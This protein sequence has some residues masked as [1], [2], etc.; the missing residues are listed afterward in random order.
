[1]LLGRNEELAGLRESLADGRPVVV[2]GPVGIGKTALVQAVCGR[3]AARVGQC[4][5]TFSHRQFHPV[6]H[7]LGRPPATLTASAVAGLVRTELGDAVL[8]VEDAHWAD[9]ASL[10][11]VVDLMR[12]RPVLLTTRTGPEAV[13][14]RR[15]VHAAGGDVVE[16]GPLPDEVL[17]DLVS[18]E[19]PSLV[20]FERRRVVAAAGGNP[21]VAIVT[22]RRRV[23]AGPGPD[24]GPAGHDA[25]AVLEAVVATLAPGDRRTLALIGRSPSPIDPQELEG[26]EAL[27]ATGLVRISAGRPEATTSLLSEVAWATL[28]EGDRHEVLRRL[29]DDP[30]LDAVARA[31]LLLQAGEVD[32]ALEL[33]SEAAG[34]PLHRAGQ[35]AALHTAALAAVA[36]AAGD[37]VPREPAEV[38][39]LLVDAAAALN[40]AARYDAAADVLTADALAAVVPS[41]DEAV[42]LVRAAMGGG[43][44]TFRSSVVQRLEPHVNELVRRSSRFATLWSVLTERP[45][46]GVAVAPLDEHLFA[47]STSAADRSHAAFLQMRIAMAEDPGNAV[48]WM[49]VVQRE[50]Q[51]VADPTSDLEAARN[52]VLVHLALGNNDEVR[53]LAAKC[54]ERADEAGL[55]AWSTEF[56]THEVISRFHEGLEHDDDLDWLSWVRTAPV[57]LE[58]RA[59][60]MS[61]LVTLLADRGAA[62]RSAEVLAPWLAPSAL[63]GFDPMGQAIVIWTAAQ[64]AWAVGDLA[65]TT[66]LARWITG[67][68][69]PGFPT[70]AGTHVVWRWAEFEA[71]EPLTAPDPAGGGRPC[72]AIEADAVRLLADGA[73][74]QAARKFEEAA[75]EWSKLLRRCALRCRWGDGLALVRA[76]RAE[77]VKG[78]EGLDAEL[79]AAGFPAL[80]PRVH[81]ALR[82]AGASVRGASDPAIAGLSARQSQVLSL[83]AEGRTTAQ[84]AAR[85]GLSPETV[86][87]HVRAGMEKLGARTRVEAAAVVGLAGG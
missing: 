72:A 39:R 48:L 67:R 46:G 84:I 34:G 79:D 21:L 17:E 57:R 2:Q 9:D 55:T 26:A 77:G 41:P 36:L 7:A 53:A 35:A 87:S 82:E 23:H 68:V 18:I 1:M 62:A 42:E 64:R 52:L 56:R 31:E 59:T 50:G 13:T 49:D 37:G 32:D 63:E 24:E 33:A 78:L 65:E 43:D 30:A 38:R 70:L 69:P 40:D 44:G 11:V 74:L 14:V 15:L 4:L 45:V 80:R 58:T 5:P 85:L 60:A 76:G 86:N 81:A 25:A 73:H 47:G 71:G 27:L 75:T 54:V 20:A 61:A 10:E 8:V 29:L 12:D 19:V 3:I 22:A 51:D 83:V 6:L 28:D 66:R 16:P